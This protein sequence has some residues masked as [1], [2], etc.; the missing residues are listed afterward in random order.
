MTTAGPANAASAFP[1]G[2]RIDF[3]TT[4]LTN[5]PNSPGD[6]AGDLILEGIPGYA[7]LIERCTML[8]RPTVEASGPYD[9]ALM[10]AKDGLNLSIASAAFGTPFLAHDTRPFFGRM[11]SLV[12]PIALEDLDGAAICLGHASNDPSGTGLE[13]TL[14]LDIAYRTIKLRTLVG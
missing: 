1:G 2:G 8:V 9:Y 14:D 11:L 10:Y 4:E 3:H 6:P 13:G 7:I 12:M 5:A